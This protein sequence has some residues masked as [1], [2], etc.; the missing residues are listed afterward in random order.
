MSVQQ[1]WNL[2]QLLGLFTFSKLAKLSWNF[3]TESANKVLKLR[4]VDYVVKNWALAMMSKALPLVHFWSTL[5]VKDQMMTSVR[6][7]LKTLVWSAKNRVISSEICAE[8]NHKIS[9]FVLIAFRRS[10]PQKS[11]EIGRFSHKFL[12]K[13]PS[14]FDFFF[15]DLSEA[16]QSV[17]KYF[18]GSFL[19]SSLS[20]LIFPTIQAQWIWKKNHR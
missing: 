18:S 6:K 14:K 1:I 19:S 11:P 4:G 12:P 10:L 15:R 17:V 2:S 3:V 16:L 9:R 13:N 8:N 7:K 20:F 5:L